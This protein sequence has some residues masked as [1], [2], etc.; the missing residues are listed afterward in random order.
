M[1][2]TDALFTPSEGF[3]VRAD[4]EHAAAY[5]GS[6]F[7]YSRLLAEGSTYTGDPG[8]VVLA[9]RIRGGIGWSRESNGSD[10]GLNPQKRFF[11]GGS[12]SVRGFG[13]FRLGPTVLGVDAVTWLAAVDTVPDDGVVDGAGCSVAEINDRSCD[14]RPLASRPGAFEARPAGGEL[15]VEGNIELRFPLPFA[16]GKLRGA[17]FL[18]AGQ[19]WAENDR[20]DG[21]ELVATP[22]VGVRYL[23]PVGPIRIDA[24]FNLQGSR[25]LPVVTTEVE[26]CIRGTEGCVPLE[27]AR[28]PLKNTDEIV[29]LDQRID[30][31][32]FTSGLDTLAGW[33]Q[34]FQLHF[35]IGQAF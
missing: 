5:T 14:P 27:S 1:D 31:Q 35:A 13:P 32:P 10:I 4:L 20:F 12:N 28:L 33:F 17:A 26:E 8:G 11:A 18:D 16:G 34:R 23:S 7:A 21:R 24:G 29:V 25:S 19:V 22:G 6:D 3:V 15:L 2:R 30:Y 9:T